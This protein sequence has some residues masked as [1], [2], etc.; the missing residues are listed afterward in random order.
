MGFC[1]IEMEFD[2]CYGIR[3]SLEMHV[4]I[5]KEEESRRFNPS[6]LVRRM[7]ILVWRR[8]ALM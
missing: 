2:E 8:A 5:S 3:V 4:P 6:A 7:T 1:Y